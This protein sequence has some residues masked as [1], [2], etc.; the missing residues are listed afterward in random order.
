V[1]TRP[2]A[3][4]TVTAVM[5]LALLA[6]L[7]LALTGFMRSQAAR[8]TR[9]QADAQMRQLLHAGATIASDLP[10][11]W[12]S[13]TA[14]AQSLRPAL[15]PAMAEGFIEITTGPTDGDH[16]WARVRATIGTKTSSQ[17][18]RFARD[19]GIWA[20]AGITPE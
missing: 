4:A 3:F 7:S 6:S 5:M 16:A 14:Q 13:G 12:G 17:T 1:R 19:G 9:D 10:A 18:L 11:V 20:L 15:P 2:R 8:T